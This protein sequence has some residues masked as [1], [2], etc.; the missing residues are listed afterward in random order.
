[1]TTTTYTMKMALATD[2][3]L[4]VAYD[5]LGLLDNLEHDYYP[6]DESDE[7]APTYIDVDDQQHL[8]L[9]YD[10]LKAIVD[11]R[12][13]GALHRVVCG[14]STV[15]SEKN[16]VL[17][18]TKDVVELHP[19]IKA[20]LAAAER[21]RTPDFAAIEDKRMSELTPEQQ[22]D[23]H[24]MWLRKQSGWFNEDT[25]RHVEF[26]LKRLDAVRTGAPHA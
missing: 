21:V 5:L 3:D 7:D 22:D 24:E 1:M 6:A 14:F 20:A 23:A 18:L 9:F 19:R 11:R 4:D 25:R 2:E 13:S 12:G 8:R 26:L 15:R 16:Q 17:D 10:K